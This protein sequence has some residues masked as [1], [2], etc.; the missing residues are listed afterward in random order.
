MWI[1]GIGTA[2]VVHAGGPLTASNRKDLQGLVLDALARGER[3]VAVNLDG[4]GYVD[5][6]A[7]GTLVLLANRARAQGGAFRLE[8]VSGEVQALLALTRLDGLLLGAD[9][10]GEYAAAG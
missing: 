9:D 1:S 10:A 5:T 8:R 2:V 7:L 4:A 6:A 3:D